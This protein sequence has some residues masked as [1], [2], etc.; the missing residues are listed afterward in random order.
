MLSLPWGWKNHEYVPLFERFKSQ[1]S[2]LE[3]CS[4]KPGIEYKT[5]AKHITPVFRSEIK[6]FCE[7]ELKKDICR[8]EP[9][10]ITQ[11]R[12]YSS[13]S[14]ASEKNLLIEMLPSSRT[15]RNG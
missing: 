6:E 1:W 11:A 15:F 4:I 14:M 8:D 10:E 9:I 5:V 7:P 3:R 2:D 13:R 12:P